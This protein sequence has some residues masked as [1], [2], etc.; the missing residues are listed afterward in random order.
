MLNGKLKEDGRVDLEVGTETLNLSATEL[1]HLMQVLS[2]LRAKMPE[3]VPDKQ[4]QIA[5]VSYNPLYHVRLDKE[6]KA[7]LLSLRH[8]GL[9]WINFELPTQEVLNMRTMWNHIVERMELEPPAGYYDG[10]ER[11]RSQPH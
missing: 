10:P 9:G 5:S 2:D 8:P 3:P 11:R 6:T 1:D 7:C 4:Q